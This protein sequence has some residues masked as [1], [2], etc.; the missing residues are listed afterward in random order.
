M[1]VIS[2]HV[3]L[4]AHEGSLIFCNVAAVETHTYDELPTNTNHEWWEQFQMN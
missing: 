4:E 3:I 1:P 2:S